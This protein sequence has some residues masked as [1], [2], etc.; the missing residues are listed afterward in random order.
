MPAKSNERIVQLGEALVPGITADPRWPGLAQQ[1]HL[2]DRLGPGRAELQAT[3]SPQ[4]LPIEEPA[5]VLT[6]RLV[7]AVNGRISVPASS[8][9]TATKEPNHRRQATPR[10]ASPYAPLRAAR[11]YE[12]VPTPKQ[13][14]RPATTY[15][16]TPRPGPKR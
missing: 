6:Y 8:T 15:D 9:S 1:L 16:P 2:A 13:P 7:E 3:A 10:P 14:Y 4:P 11:P 5:A 12:P